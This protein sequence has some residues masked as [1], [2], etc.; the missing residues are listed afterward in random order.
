MTIRRFVCCLPLLFASPV[1]AQGSETF[2]DVRAL[3]R[4]GDSIEVTDTA[5]R[6]VAGRLVEVSADSLSVD[7]STIGSSQVRR[8]RLAPAGVDRIV[9]GQR[10]SIANGV[11]LGA[12]AGMG[13][14][15]AMLLSSGGCDC[16]AAETWMKVLGPYVAIGAGAGAALDLAFKGKTTIY[17]SRDGR[18]TASISPAFS[19]SGAGVR[20]S[21]KF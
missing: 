13:G 5:G 1:F 16:Y 7:V 15:F 4:P 3:V 2:G 20:M 14:G 8:V 9:R 6:T 18:A 10:D 21:V 12:L 17:R 19:K 11:A